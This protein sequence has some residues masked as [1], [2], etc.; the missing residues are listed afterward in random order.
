MSST[1][2]AGKTKEE[3]PQ[4]DPPAI[5]NNSIR[6]FGMGTNMTIQI[7]AAAIL[8]V[9]VNIVI[10]NYGKQ[11][12][13]T[14]NKSVEL[15]AQSIA[16]LQ[17]PILQDREKAV[18]IT[19]VINPNEFRKIFKDSQEDIVERV[20]VRLQSYADSSD[21][22][23]ELEFV[24]ALVQQGRM[25]ALSEQYNV[26]FTQSMLIVDARESSD[27]NPPAET[28]SLYQAQYPQYTEDQIIEELK[29][30]ALGK[31]IRFVPFSELFI[32]D[33][34][35]N[36]ANKAFISLW[37]DEAEITTNIMRAIEGKPKKIYFLYDKCQIDSKRGGK[38]PWEFVRDAFK[39]QNILLENLSLSQLPKKII[40]GKSI[41]AI[42]DDAD[43]IALI[44]PQVDFT[45][46]ELISLAEY[47]EA[48]DG[49]S[50]L[51]TLD[52]EVHLPQ[53]NTYLL[54]SQITPN[55][56]RIVRIEGDQVLVNPE[57][58]FLR[59]PQVNGTL[60]GKSTT[61]AGASQ[62]IRI[63][64]DNSNSGVEAFPLVQ[65]GANWWG[66]TQFGQSSLPTFDQRSD[67][68][69]PLYLGVAVTR[70]KLSDPLTK[71]LVS[72]MVVLGNSEFLNRNQIR[73]EQ[74][75]FLNQIGT[76]LVGRE[77]LMSL[78]Q[79]SNQRRK[80]FIAASHRSLIN[81]I[82]LFFLPALAF[83]ITGFVWNSRRS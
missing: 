15:T 5:K 47:W 51:I 20:K 2:D 14:K 83:I 9:G 58:E 19:A 63:R 71:H 74:Q 79:P 8:L 34:D 25:Q 44:S 1:S 32:S 66:E 38:A 21:G 6:R 12:D 23:I 49:A 55:K 75:E 7:I 59:G 43:G 35:K 26:K 56:D 48:R 37:K 33:L 53:L 68:Q 17:S 42:P 39:G 11:H 31:N 27:Y 78:P 46:E 72:K 54:R 62:S 61:F 10:F 29:R 70:G 50:V 64:P 30:E 52:P 73:D 60:A 69:L 18:K 3:E 82:F 40:N 22:K 57:V 81:Q 80:V 13:L 45:A 77:P 65:V 24:N 28:V 76:W 67:S 4:K 41:K 16:N 36:Y